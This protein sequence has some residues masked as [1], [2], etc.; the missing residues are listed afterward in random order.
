MGWGVGDSHLFQKDSSLLQRKQR[1]KKLNVKKTSASV[2]N[3]Y[4]Q[5]SNKP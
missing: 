5:I 3:D 2:I 1:E 4:C